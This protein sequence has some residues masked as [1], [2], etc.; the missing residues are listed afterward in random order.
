METGEY[1]EIPERLDDQ[2]AW[3]SRSSQRHRRAYYVLKTI[4]IASAGAIPV[5]AAA[6]ADAV[7]MA[8]L[9][10]LVLAVESV[11]QLLQNQQHWT[12]Y[13]L[14]AE[15]LKRER[16]LFLSRAGP[17]RT[18]KDAHA[19]LVERME[20]RVAAETGGWRQIQQDA[21]TTRDAG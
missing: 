9:G 20:G 21:A 7:V 13:R 3:Y 8:M 6:N 14:T 10:S 15:D 18:A 16:S 4:T 5:V 17:Y 1:H 19:L 2:I 12:A 11:Q